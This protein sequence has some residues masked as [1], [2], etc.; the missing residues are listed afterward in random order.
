MPIRRLLPVTLWLGIAA[1][2]AGCS[3]PTEPQITPL[4]DS[5]HIPS[6]MASSRATV[7]NLV[8][9]TRPPRVTL[10]PLPIILLLGSSGAEER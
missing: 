7:P 4:I 6:E 3:E 2:L 5:Y 9:F 10:E 1:S 8:P